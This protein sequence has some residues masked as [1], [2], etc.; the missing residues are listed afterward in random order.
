MQEAGYILLMP[1]GDWNAN[2]AYHIL[3]LVNHSGASWVCKKDCTG[4][5][6]SDS[7][8]T[9][10][11]RFGTAVDLSN[12]F[13]KSGGTINGNVSVKS[14]EAVARQINMMNSVRR[15]YQNINAN[16]VYQLYDSTNNK[17]IIYS[18]LDGTNTFNGTASGNLPLSGGGTVTS[19]ADTPIIVKT[20]NA[21]HNEVYMGYTATDKWS[22]F[23]GFKNGEPYVYNK[24][25]I[26]YAG[27]KPTGTYT[28]NGDATKRTINIGSSMPRSIIVT[29][30]NGMV[31]M[32]YYGA[33]YKETSGT[34]VSGLSWG[35][36][37]LLDTGNI[38]LITTN[39]MLNASGVVYTYYSV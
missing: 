29:S 24:G 10:W 19:N 36:C 30:S 3:H 26:F 31:L 14:D 8:T 39:P 34:T 11:Q 7:N 15:V 23:M 1:G 25:A 28:G 4:Q 17:G 5:E 35:E 9:Y 12:Y 18:Y 33:I 21:N 16:G 27:N 20:V 38:Q 22:A 2:T 13:P 6:P 32:T 37:A